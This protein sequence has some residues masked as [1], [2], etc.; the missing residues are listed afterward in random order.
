MQTCNSISQLACYITGTQLLLQWNTLVKIFFFFKYT[1]YN[2]LLKNTLK[3]YMQTCSSISQH[4]C[5]VT[6]T[7]FDASIGRISRVFHRDY[8]ILLQGFPKFLL[9]KLYLQLSG[10]DRHQH[11]NPTPR[12]ALF[13]RSFVRSF[14]RHEKIPHQRYMHQGPGSW[15]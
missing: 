5:Y 12:I 13:V 7:P 1:F 11:Q 9:L 15:I 4:A 2:T 14:V 8:T 3:K 6:G 10:I